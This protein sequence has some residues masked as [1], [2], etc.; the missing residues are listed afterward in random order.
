[1]KLCTLSALLVIGLLISCRDNEVTTREEIREE[2]RDAVRDAKEEV[3]ETRREV[4]DTTT[5]S[6]ERLHWKGNWNETKG[7]IKQRFADLTDDDLLYQ[8]GQEDEMLGRL[9]QRLG[10][11]RE[12]IEAILNNP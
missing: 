9:Q 8:E 5:A 7:K 1:M 11:T 10:K 6:P 3:A 4:V 12:E 2:V